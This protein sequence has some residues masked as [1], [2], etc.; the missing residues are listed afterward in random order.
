MCGLRLRRRRARGVESRLVYA[1]QP[2][3][4]VCSGWRAAAF[5][6][7]LYRVLQ[8]K[9]HVSRLHIMEAADM[10]RLLLTVRGERVPV[11][12]CSCRSVQCR[13]VTRRRAD[14]KQLLARGERERAAARRV[15]ME[16]GSR[17]GPWVATHVEAVHARQHAARAAPL[18]RDAQCSERCDASAP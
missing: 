8:R 10:P 3:E 15:I 2:Y 18:P 5:C 1:V 4:C 17:A 13:R 16:A 11:A 9:E 14:V 6:F 12:G 7:G